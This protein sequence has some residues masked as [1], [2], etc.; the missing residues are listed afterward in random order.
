MMPATRTLTSRRAERVSS[1]PLIDWQTLAR[2]RIN[3]FALTGR[4][5]TAEPRHRTPHPGGEAGARSGTNLGVEQRGDMTTMI[6]AITA[7]TTQRS[8]TTVA[9]ACTGSWCRVDA[10]SKFAEK[11]KVE[12][13]SR[14]IV[15]RSCG[16]LLRVWIR[17]DKIRR[18]LVVT[19]R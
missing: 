14:R 16:L 4:L 12:I 2:A 1:T 7:S 17:D 15:L 18:S 9:E 8:V 5:R 19:I 10:S 3:S 6:A 13:N 11:P